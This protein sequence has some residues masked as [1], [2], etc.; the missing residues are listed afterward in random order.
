[1]FLSVVE[2]E[3]MNA[4]EQDTIPSLTADEW[5]ALRNHKQNTEVAIQEADKG[6]AVAIM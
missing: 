2:S 5:Q 3:M 6:S 4:P 1:M